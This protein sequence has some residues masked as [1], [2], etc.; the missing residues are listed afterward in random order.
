MGETY[1]PLSWATLKYDARKGG[2]VVNLDKRP[3]EGAPSYDRN[4]E[5]KWTPDHGRRVDSYYSVPKLLDIICCV[6]EPRPSAAGIARNRRQRHGQ[7]SYRRR[8]KQA[9]GAVKEA[10]GKVIGDA[11]LV[12]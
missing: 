11:K 4:S 5:F 8:G 2:Y 1:H 10:A 9:K 12:P 7:G 3:L 6:P